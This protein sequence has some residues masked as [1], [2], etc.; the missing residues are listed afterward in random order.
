L[1]PDLE[2]SS[3]VGDLRRETERLAELAEETLQIVKDNLA[4]FGRHDEIGAS[5]LG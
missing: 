4:M 1:P 2:K 3:S 5:V